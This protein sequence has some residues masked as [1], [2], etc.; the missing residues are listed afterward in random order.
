MGF[1][2]KNGNS[3]IN[4][5]QK[6]RISLTRKALYTMSEDINTFGIKNNSAFI[7]IVFDNFK[8]EAKSS[9]SLQLQ[10]R[11][12]ELEM[13]FANSNMDPAL[14]KNL[15]DKLLSE[16]EDDLKKEIAQDNDDTQKDF[17]K[18]TGI[19][20]TYRINN[21]NIEYLTEDCS[22][23][24]YYNHA[25]QYICSIIKEY[26]SLPF[27]ERE[28]IIKKDTYEI[29]EQACREKKILKIKAPINGKEQLFYVYP[30]KILPD[31]F[32]T[33]SYLVC[34]SRKSGKDESSKIV[35][36]FSMARLKMPTM[37]N[38]KFHLNQKELKNIK[39]QLSDNSPAYLIGKP[40]QIAVRLSKK[41]KQNYQA[42]LY[43]RPEKID[44]LSTDDIYIFNCTQQQIINYFFSFGKEAEIIS[45]QD[46]RKRFMETYEKALNKYK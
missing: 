10:Q 33:Q 22:E 29:V 15:I 35:A 13:L 6:I 24:K 21:K 7:N 30:Y 23:E 41:G 4:E 20:H 43:S 9:I 46:L 37:L 14:K 44:E 18:Y 2:Y 26:C 19:P 25:G 45:P 28:R 17:S 40:E 42:R 8:D 1:T 39:K 5:Q 32:H 11:R 16:K 31:L 36:S 3:L 12:V 34:Y 27:I 38:Q